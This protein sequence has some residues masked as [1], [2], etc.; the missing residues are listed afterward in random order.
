MCLRV[1]NS[2]RELLAERTVGSKAN[3]QSYWELRC[4]VSIISG[5]YSL[6]LPS[7]PRG[8]KK[9]LLSF[10]GAR[11]GLGGLAATVVVVGVGVGIGG[12]SLFDSD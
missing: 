12:S 1:S 10:L 4:E 3:D 5:K 6:G 9:G 7:F 8:L 11:E 2:L